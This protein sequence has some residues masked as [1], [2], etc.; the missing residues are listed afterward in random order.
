[1]TYTNNPHKT[2][3]LNVINQI[4]TDRHRYMVFQDFVE[5]AA[6]SLHN[7]FAMSQELEDIYLQ[8]AKR[9]SKSDLMKLSCLLAITVKGLT[10]MPGD[11]LGDIFMS[12]GF[13][14]ACRGQFYTPSNL[15]EMICKITLD[16]VDALIEK[17]G[18]LTVS[19]P[20]CGA[21]SMAVAYAMEVKK[22][23]YDL[24]TQFFIQCVDIDPI[25]T[26]MTFIQLTL[27][28]VPAEVV[29]GDSLTLECTKSMCTPGYYL[30]GWKR[31]LQ[32]K[33]Q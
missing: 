3:F 13:G 23:G 21:G 18:F 17:N 19:E 22:R 2:E 5:M 33:K 1:M 14:D 31:R 9:Y 7:R 12:L 11:F 16:S 25:A 26:A 6:I 10:P 28:G 32:T 29:T 30:F 8:K 20:A 15:A 24:N 27:V 4:A